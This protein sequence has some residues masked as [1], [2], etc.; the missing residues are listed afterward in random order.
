MAGRK[1]NNGGAKR[2]A[3]ADSHP[4]PRTKVNAMS[5]EDISEKKKLRPDPD[6][7]SVQQLYLNYLFLEGIG[8]LG[9]QSLRRGQ[10]FF[11]CSTLHPPSPDYQ[12][13]SL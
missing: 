1:N 12:T 8:T 13:D 10:C 2:G 9:A 7:D 3:L 11:G 5:K 4:G 6:P